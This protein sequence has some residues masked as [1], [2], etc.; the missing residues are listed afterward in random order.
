MSRRGRFITFEGIDGAGKSTQIAL[1]QE[2]LR[3]HGVDVLRT[4]E[5]GG[6]EVGERLREL[7]L[8][9]KMSERTETLL[10]FAARAEHVDKVIEPALAE[11][12]WV[13]CDRFTDATF[14]YQAGGRRM[15]PELIAVLEWWVHP[16]LQPDVTLLFDID[17]ALAA[18]RLS[19]VRT[20][21]RF[22]AEQVEFFNRVRAHYLER[23]KLH[24]NRFVIIQAARPA[25]EVQSAVGQLVDSWFR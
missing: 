11:G 25:E 7:V 19:R 16:Q 3:A 17:P 12:R 22:E 2:R 21:D 24:A 15:N 18:S 14:A 5:P 23:A 4:R 20:A 6:T 9:Q 10:M 8:H 13:L 1:V